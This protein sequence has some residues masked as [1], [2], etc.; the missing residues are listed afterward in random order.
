MHQDRDVEAREAQRLGDSLLIAKVGQRHDYAVNLVTIGAEQ[1]G[2]LL[3]FFSRLDRAMLG[4]LR[5]RRDHVVSRGFENAQH[6]LAAGLGQ[7]IGKEA[8]VSDDESEGH[9][10]LPGR[11]RYV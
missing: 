1:C 10:R 11:N 8:A 6:L 5:R 9:A 2:A 7:M 3:G 4:L